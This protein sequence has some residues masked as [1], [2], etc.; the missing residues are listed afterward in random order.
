MTK[1]KIIGFYPGFDMRLGDPGITN[2]LKEKHGGKHA[3]HKLQK[4]Q[5]ILLRNR[6]INKIKIVDKRGIYCMNL[7][8]KQTFDLALRLNQILKF[9]GESLG[10]EYQASKVVELTL[11]KFKKNELM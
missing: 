7:P 2:F 11:E 10:L 8:G 6:A 4:G 1:V 5:V 9:V 3:R